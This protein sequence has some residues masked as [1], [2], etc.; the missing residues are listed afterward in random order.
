M[1]ST[2]PLLGFFVAALA[3]AAAPAAHAAP[4]T[5]TGGSVTGL[6]HD[7]T[8]AG[9]CTVPSGS[10]LLVSGNLT[11]APGAKFN[12]VTMS[13]VTISGNVNVKKGATFGLG[14]TPASPVPPCDPNTPTHDVVGGNIT[15]DRPLTMYLD[16]DTITGNVQSNGGGPGPTLSPYINFPI[17]DNVISGN[18]TVDGWQGAWFGVIRNVVGGNVTV[19]KTVGVTI[20]DLGTLDSTEV[21]TNTIGGNLDCRNNNPAAQLGDTGGTVN[22]VAGQ[23]KGECAAL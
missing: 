16:G 1:R 23:K 19:A 7:L 8:I 10:S 21:A 18:L 20:G 3:L 12:A 13:T 9:N 6:W 15:A 22:T 2:R 11:V 17:K 5:C 4:A 14:C